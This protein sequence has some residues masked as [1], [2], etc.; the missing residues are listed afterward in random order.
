MDIYEKPPIKDYLVHY[1]IKGMKW[2]IRR[3]PEQLGHLRNPKRA[4][5]KDAKE[6]ARAKMFYGEGAG[7]RRKLINNT[8]EERSKNP[9]YKKAFD[10]A[11]SKQDMAKH[12][13]KAKAE[14]RVRDAKNTA[15]KTGRGVI[16]MMTGHPERLSA[17]MAAVA[18]M[19]AIAH[20]TGADKVAISAAR[21][22]YRS[23]VNDITIAKGKRAVD[24]ILNR[25]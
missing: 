8:V 25:K 2:G 14:R 16:N 22:A 12:V 1:G 11:L 7:T 15:A 24:K 3:T 10:E 4:A 13:Q 5:R 6:Y 18:S 23:I 19:L 9:D 21:K 20:K 17:G